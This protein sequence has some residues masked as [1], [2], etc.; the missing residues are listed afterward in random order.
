MADSQPSQ[1]T[2]PPPQ[3]ADSNAAVHTL[4]TLIQLES[5][6]R[7]AELAEARFIAVNEFQ[8]LVP[9]YQSFLFEGM[10]GDPPTHYD[11]TTASGVVQ[12]EPDSEI[13]QHLKAMLTTLE[14]LPEKP[15]I[16][17]ASVPANKKPGKKSQASAD[18]ELQTGPP[19]P[20]YAALIPVVPKKGTR[21][22]LL[23]V[24]R[25]QPFTQGEMNLLEKCA[26]ALAAVFQQN[27]SLSLWDKIRRGFADRRKWKVFALIAAL[28]LFFPVRTSVLAPAEVVPKDPTMVRAP[29]HGIIAS[30]PVKPNQMVKKGDV[31]LTFDK[32]ELTA[33][34]SVAQSSVTSSASELRQ[35]SQQSFSDPQARLRLA[36][37]QGEFEK[38]KSELAKA[39]NLLARTEITAAIDGVVIFDNVYD[40]LGQ[41]VDIGEKI[42][43]LAAPRDTQL[44][45]RLPVVDA[46][47]L[48]EDASIRFFSNAAPYAPVGATMS[49]QSYRATKDELGNISYRIDGTWKDADNANL[50]LGSKGTAKLYGPYRPIIWAVLRKPL[51]IARQWLGF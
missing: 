12:P 5:R 43:L 49:F 16:R 38:A 17:V 20:E 15:E 36:N 8:Q 7:W 24:L 33:Q 30:I 29:I 40:W 13:M 42:M 9:L 44:E 37:A 11:L 41:Q 23:V 19:L 51:S 6:L 48:Q 47:P 1:Q 2:Q 4:L 10:A 32:T 14:A 34:M 18:E 46:I 50:K 27:P 22:A 39:Q 26:D 21:R 28:I 45:V 31:L 25:H 35:I 3:P